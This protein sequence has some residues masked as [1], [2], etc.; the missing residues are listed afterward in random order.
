MAQS[1]YSAP[2]YYITV[3]VDMAEGAAF[4]TTLKTFK[5]SYSDL[6]AY[7]VA[8]ALREY[9]AVNARW[10]EDAVEEVGDVNLG[11]AVALPTGLIVP[12]IRQVQNKSLEGIH[13]ESRALIDKAR[14]GKLLPD[15]YVG[16]TFTISNLGVFGVDH[17]TAIINQP[18]SAILAV[19]TIKE[20]PVVIDG[21]IH[22]RPMMNLTLSSDHR[23][24]DGAVAAQFMGRLR[25]ILENGEF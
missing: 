10:A 22:V 19:G 2:H 24:I 5:P 23:V 12:V 15:D 8:K 17:F 13:H 21:G 7:A 20:K 11:L 25:E 9:P 14:N 3:E 6:L 16:N 4:R 18:D 1:F